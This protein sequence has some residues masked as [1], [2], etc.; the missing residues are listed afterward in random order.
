MLCL[1]VLNSFVDVGLE[2]KGALLCMR[3]RLIL[4]MSLVLC[5]LDPI[6][7]RAASAALL[8]TSQKYL[9]VLKV[10]KVLCLFF[11]SGVVDVK[12]ECDGGREEGL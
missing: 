8:F 3:L 1:I 11:I 12:S 9:F 4:L 6:R 2:R 10:L 5:L 7:F